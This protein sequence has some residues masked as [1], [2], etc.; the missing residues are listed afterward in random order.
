MPDQGLLQNILS[1]LSDLPWQQR[2]ARLAEYSDYN[3]VFSTSFSVE[4]QAITHVVADRDLPIRLFTIDTGRLF[5]QTHEVS[6]KTRD[7]YPD[8]I[9][10]T[11][12]PNNVLVQNLVKDQGVNGFFESSD[13]RHAC[14]HV[15]KVEPLGR[16]LDG[17]DIWISGL[18]RE[19]SNNRGDLPVAEMDAGRNVIKVYPLI[20]V[21][22]SEIKDFVNKYDVPYNI[23]HDQ[24]FPS[25]GCAPC[26]RAVKEGDHPRSGRWWWEQDNAQECGLH[27]VDGKLV[28]ASSL[29]GKESLN[30]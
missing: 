17:A 9:F 16:A 29:K 25:I 14:C 10:D 20:D 12:Y 8:I 27:L 18:R 19:H 21:L 15:R 1:D 26:T 28:R 24:G 5:E 23:L 3:I 4:D 13:K 11:H 22:E 2:L 6:Q 30:A 7:R